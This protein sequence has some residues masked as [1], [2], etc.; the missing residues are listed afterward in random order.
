MNL[1]IIDTLKERLE[2]RKKMVTG[3]KEVTEWIRVYEVLNA[4]YEDSL[5]GLYNKLSEEDQI[6]TYIL[7]S[8]DT[9]KYAEEMLFW[10]TFMPEWQRNACRIVS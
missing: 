9:P 7:M 6:S 4:N 10:I 5:R 2:I 8:H 3:R 1:D